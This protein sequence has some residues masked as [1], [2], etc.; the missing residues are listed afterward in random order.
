MAIIRAPLMGTL[1]M[2]FESAAI[3]DMFILK[4]SS[5]IGTQLE[6]F[7]LDWRL[8]AMRFMTPKAVS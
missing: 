1:S 3:E 8:P 4:L 6:G 2:S 5:V 7:S